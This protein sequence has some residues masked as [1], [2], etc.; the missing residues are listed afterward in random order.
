MKNLRVALITLVLLAMCLPVA[1]VS[2]E[3]APVEK[4]VYAMLADPATMTDV[5]AVLEKM[6]AITRESIGVELE[7][8]F[9]Y[10]KEP[11]QTTMQLMIS[12]GEDLD[13]MMTDDNQYVDQI[14]QNMLMPLGEL[15]EQYGQGI[16]EAYSD[17]LSFWLDNLYVNGE[18]Y[19]IPIM[20]DPSYIRC[21]AMRAD[22][23]AETGYT[24]DDI[25]EFADLEKVLA[26]VHEL[27][28]NMNCLVPYA[29]LTCAMPACTAAYYNDL[30][31]SFG[32]LV[33]ETYNVV[34]LWTYEP[35]V[36]QLRLLNRWY[37][38]GYILPYAATNPTPGEAWVREGNTFA[39]G[40]GVETFDYET[41]KNIFTKN[42]GYE[43]EVAYIQDPLLTSYDGT[44]TIPSTS[45]HA[46]A[47]MKYVNELYTNHELMTLFYCG[48][49]GTN[50]VLDETGRRDYPEGVDASNNT[51]TEQKVMAGNQLL[52]PPWNYQ[53]ETWRD[54]VMEFWKTVNVS[55]AMGFHFDYT[56]LETEYAAVTSVLAEYKQGLYNGVLDFDSAYPQF[57]AAMEEAGLNKIIEAKQAQLNEWAA[58]K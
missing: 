43:M 38:A 55:P 58:A 2:A 5:N 51:W 28:P 36:E 44:I 20:K 24:V 40:K 12:G 52:T 11:L 21:F 39:Y 23:L 8:I 49:E 17:G 32:V 3:E 54:D 18:I 30:G 4:I 22:I 57:L 50:Y 9:G 47:A 46:A 27:Y 13:L 16:L 15:Y 53:S 19:A 25:Q 42:C 26:K 35:F 31:D 48:I 56:G 14:S 45:K 37:Q 33:D 41:A 29:S 34:N 1:G 7:L 10:P 6:N